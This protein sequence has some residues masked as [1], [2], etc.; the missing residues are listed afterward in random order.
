MSRSCLLLLA[1]LVL[2]APAQPPPLEK[3]DIEIRYRIDA[4]RNERAAQFKE[5][6]S[7][8]NQLGFERDPTDG[9]KGDENLEEQNSLVSRLS[10]TIPGTTARR[11]ARLRH[12]LSIQLK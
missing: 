8:L 5:M 10:G 6:M 11:V 4:F 2:P 12:V 3:Y 1:L 7:K 9:R